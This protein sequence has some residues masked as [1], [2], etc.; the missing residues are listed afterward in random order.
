MPKEDVMTNPSKLDEIEVRASKATEGPWEVGGMDSG[1]SAFEMSI[2]VTTGNGDSICDMDGQV[3]ALN[4]A[5]PN[6]DGLADA[7]FIAHA[8][9]DVPRLV[10]AL[11]AVEAVC[12]AWTARGE[13]DMAYS[14]TIPDENIADVLL[15]DG[16]EKIESARIIRDAI[17]EALGE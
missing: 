14:K 15:T 7:D 3:R 13:H 9:E 1:H 12:D 10:A 11:R 16:A 17:R 8:R 5:P 2:W 4:V 6:D